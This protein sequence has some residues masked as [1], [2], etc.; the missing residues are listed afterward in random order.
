[1]AIH[2]VYRGARTLMGLML[3]WLVSGAAQAQVQFLDRVPSPGEVRA[4]L[5][6]AA[7]GAVRHPSWKPRGI[8]WTASSSDAASTAADRAAPTPSNSAQA[9]ALAFPIQFNS[10]HSRVLG[11]SVPY[12]E[13]IAKTLAQYPDMRLAIEGHTDAAGQPRSNMVL[14]W[15]RSLAVYR[16]LVERFAIDPSRLQPVGK[17]AS[18]PLEQA[19]TAP[20]MN[21]RVQFR[22]VS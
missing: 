7:Q 5:A 12:V 1:M 3:C 19:N 22:V 8:E 9:P 17:G 14:S 4:I 6:P 13:A 18:E 16:L 21:R 20:G 2:Y 10:G 11:T 15:E